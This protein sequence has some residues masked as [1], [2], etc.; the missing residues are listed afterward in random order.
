L[1]KIKTLI[2]KDTVEVRQFVISQ[3][4]HYGYDVQ[5]GWW[6]VYAQG[7]IPV[8]LVAHIDTVHA[9]A[10]KQVFYDQKRKV[11]WSPDG[12]GADDRA[13]V[14]AILY[15]LEAGYRPSVL[16]TDLE[17]FGGGGAKEA[18]KEITPAGI[19]YLLEIDR[20][21]SRDAVFYDED[22]EDFKQY[23]EAFGFKEA[24]GTFS[25][26][27]ILTPEW[28][29]AGVNVSTGY[30]MEH[31]KSEYLCVAELMASVY[32]V[33][34]MLS[35]ADKAPVFKHVEPKPEPRKYLGWSYWFDRNK[36]DWVQCYLCTN[37][38]SPEDQYVWEDEFQEEWVLCPECARI[39]N[40]G[41]SRD[42][43]AVKLHQ[44][45]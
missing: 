28:G 39:I 17:E 43:M 5:E 7:T 10:P 13:G 45:G 3:L 38:V 42:T 32:K 21:G 44:D 29:I 16:F 15:I 25:D 36:T 41:A 31:S 35:V 12:L 11:L 34:Q 18:A 19:K 37:W 6:Y 1:I 4:R 27:S 9:E 14:W 33:M 24:L 8:C 26:I 23:V 30:Y 40:E 20:R 22:N 2:K